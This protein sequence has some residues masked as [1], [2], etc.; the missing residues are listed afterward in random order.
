LCAFFQASQT[1]VDF[2]HGATLFVQK[3]IKKEKDITFWFDNEYFNWR[4]NF[5]ACASPPGIPST[6]N[7]LENGNRLLK[8][9]ATM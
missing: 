7:S 1:D 4:Q 8:K 5:F 2:H 3:W 6:N 9:F